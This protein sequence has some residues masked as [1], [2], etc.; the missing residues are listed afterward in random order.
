M[1]FFSS[2]NAVKF[3]AE[4][5]NYIDITVMDIHVR[6]CL[7]VCAFVHVC[8]RACVY[9]TL[10]ACVEVLSSLFPKDTAPFAALVC[11]SCHTLH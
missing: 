4:L 5:L 7:C 8:V 11:P 9:V 6:L 1:V 3:H 2:C 10:C